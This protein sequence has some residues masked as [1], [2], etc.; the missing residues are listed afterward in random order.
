MATEAIERLFSRYGVCWLG[1][2]KLCPRRESP[3]HTALRNSPG[4]CSLGCFLSV[5]DE[6]QTVCAEQ[7]VVAETLR[8]CLAT[9]Q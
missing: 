4:I 3:H 6:V 2:Y 5:V 9:T 8:A 7:S 1:D